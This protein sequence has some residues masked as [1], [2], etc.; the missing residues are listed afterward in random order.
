[1]RDAC[2]RNLQNF[3]LT[4]TLDKQRSRAAEKYRWKMKLM[5]VSSIDSL[6]PR[7]GWITITRKRFY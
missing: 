5:D 4:F 1:M 7:R 2:E 3:I 6:E